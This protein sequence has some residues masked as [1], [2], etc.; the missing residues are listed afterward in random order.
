MTVAK[1]LY[2]KRKQTET[3]FSIINGQGFYMPKGIPIPQKEFESMFPI[4][5]SEI[6]APN[7]RY[8]GENACRKH[9]WMK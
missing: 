5:A 3:L 4:T 8:K 7:V 2:N 1:Y 6:R 9:D